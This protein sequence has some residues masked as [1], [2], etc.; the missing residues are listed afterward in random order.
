MSNI[1][2]NAKTGIQIAKKIGMDNVNDIS[3][4]DSR[5][6]IN[7]RGNALKRVEKVCKGWQRKSFDNWIVFSDSDLGNHIFI[8]KP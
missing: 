6:E 3:V 5:Y 4:M 2:N 8:Q 1:E 7:V